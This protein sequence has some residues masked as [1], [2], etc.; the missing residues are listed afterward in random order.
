MIEVKSTK[1][2]RL[3]RLQLRLP[4]GLLSADSLPQ[5]RKAWN[6]TFPPTS[7]N[8]QRDEE[9]FCNIQLQAAVPVNL[10]DPSVIGPPRLCHSLPT[11]GHASRL[12]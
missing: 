3:D 2:N 11:T 9:M 10:Q 1:P 7:L 5:P 8:R 12:E 4:P 6:V